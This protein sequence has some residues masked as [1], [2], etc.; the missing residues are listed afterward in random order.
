MSAERV[1][2]GTLKEVRK[3][4]RPRASSVRVARRLSMTAVPKNSAV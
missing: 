3:R 4:S 1:S 2:V